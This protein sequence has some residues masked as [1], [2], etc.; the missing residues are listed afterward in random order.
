[1]TQIFL[2]V[3]KISDN[4]WPKLANPQKPVRYE[5]WQLSFKVPFIIQQNVYK[6]PFFKIRTGPIEFEREE[7][8]PFD[9]NRF[10]DAAKKGVKRGLEAV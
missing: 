5:V 10:L 8:D 3:M 7:A 6:L 9:I 2:T 1:M 4:S